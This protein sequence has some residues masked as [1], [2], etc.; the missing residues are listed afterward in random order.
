M[1]FIDPMTYVIVLA[2]SLSFLSG[3]AAPAPLIEY[4]DE[5]VALPA[6]L[7]AQEPQPVVPTCT[8]DVCFMDYVFDL[9]AW[10]KKGW[11]HVAAIQ[12]AL[13]PPA[14]SK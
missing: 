10:G 11:A 6:A 4:R 1:R 14:P 13:T 7:T 8:T 5:S 2:I 12:L 3:C 9:H